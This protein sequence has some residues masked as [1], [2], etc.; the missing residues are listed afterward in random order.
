MNNKINLAEAIALE[1]RTNEIQDYIKSKQ[2]KALCNIF[3]KQAKQKIQQ[4][5]R[6][7]VSKELL[8]PG[9]RVII[10]NE[11]L[12]KKLEDICKGPYVV[13]N[14]TSNHNYNLRGR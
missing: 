7:F 1:N 10:K 12:L 11:G 13:E 3:D 9:S 2:Q 5:K 14:V 8:K 6:N 4:D